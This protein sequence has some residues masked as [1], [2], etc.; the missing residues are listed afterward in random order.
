MPREGRTSWPWTTGWPCAPSFGF[1]DSPHHR[2]RLAGGTGGIEAAG[3][4]APIYGCPPE[5][6]LPL[7]STSRRRSSAGTAPRTRWNVRLRQRPVRACRPSLV[8]GAVVDLPVKINRPW[9]FNHQMQLMSGDRTATW[10]ARELQ[11]GDGVIELRALDKRV[12]QRGMQRSGV[13]DKTLGVSIIAG[14]R[15]VSNTEVIGIECCAQ[16]K[17]QALSRFLSRFA[18]PRALSRGVE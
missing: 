10:F 16:A 14:G 4:M 3:S 8:K 1:A 5:F 13:S 9:P 2:L 6:A 11:T 17:T 18:G 7:R 15:S 12:A